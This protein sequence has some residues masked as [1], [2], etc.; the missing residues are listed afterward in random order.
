MQLAHQLRLGLG[1]AA[2]LGQSVDA[3]VHARHREKLV[4][5]QHLLEAPDG[6]QQRQAGGQIKSLFGAEFL[7]QFC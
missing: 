7:D 4:P 1:Q 3:Y 2:G 5:G 6:F